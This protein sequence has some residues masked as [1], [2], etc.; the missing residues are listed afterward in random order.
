M[1]EEYLKINILKF[2]DVVDKDIFSS[3]FTILKCLK[4]QLS[5]LKEDT[6]FIFKKNSHFFV[7][8]NIHIKVEKCSKDVS[9]QIIEIENEILGDLIAYVDHRILSSLDSCNPEYFNDG[10]F[11][12][13]DSLFSQLI[14]IQ[15]SNNNFTKRII[16]NTLLNYFLVM[17]EHI[18][19]TKEANNEFIS[20]FESSLVHKFFNALQENIFTNRTVAFYADKL[21]ISERHL[22]HIIKR[23]L[24]STP[25]Q[26]IDFSLMSSIKRLLLTTNLSIQQISDKLNFPYQ[27]NFN[28]FFTRKMKISPSEFRKNL[29]QVIQ[30]KEC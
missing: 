25:K 17:S 22:Y 20:L 5:I 29:Q 18:M 4:G 7:F 26:E 24:N 9:L 14:F 1:V 6:P 13:L 23:S 15:N 16:Q 12:M 8:E 3:K 10:D 30:N 27:A 19:K 21:N 28:Q 2:E 11:F